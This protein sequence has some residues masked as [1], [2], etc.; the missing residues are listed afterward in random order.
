MGRE[1]DGRSAVRAPTATGSAVEGRRT[2][3]SGEQPAPSRP[4]KPG[5]AVGETAGLSCE[6]PTTASCSGRVV[7][8]QSKGRAGTPSANLSFPQVAIAERL[9]IVTEIPAGVAICR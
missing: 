8:L 1:G 3:A 5:P 4:G 7:T 2:G 9:T 6:H